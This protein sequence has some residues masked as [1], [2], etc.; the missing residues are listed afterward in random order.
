MRIENTKTYDRLKKVIIEQLD[1][2]PED[3]RPESD[4]TND[5]GADSLDC[6]ELVMAI[7][8]EFEIVIPDDAAEK[9]YSLQDA[10]DFINSVVP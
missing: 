2:D 1:V 8:S 6:V 10:L 5:L 7:E 4:F 3:V 9:I